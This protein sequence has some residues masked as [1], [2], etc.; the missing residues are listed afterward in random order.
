MLYMEQ[1]N[2]KNILI[3]AFA[4]VVLALGLYVLLR[5]RAAPPELSPPRGAAPPVEQLMTEEDK[6]RI[7]QGL[8]IEKIPAAKRK[9][10][11]DAIMK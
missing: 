5:N 7:L 10:I 6:M 1:L 3:A 11:L 2:K 9:S 8:A 4:F